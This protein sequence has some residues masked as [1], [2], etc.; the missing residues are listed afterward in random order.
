MGH[1]SLVLRLQTSGLRHSIRSPPVSGVQSVVCILPAIFCGLVSPVQC[2]GSAVYGLRQ[3]DAEWRPFARLAPHLDLSAEIGH[4][5][6]GDGQPEAGPPPLGG[7]ERLKDLG[8]VLSGGPVDGVT[9]LDRT[10]LPLCP[11]YDG[12]GT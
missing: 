12:E 3:E 7:I 9:E 8:E 5:T 10:E 2:L 6:L 11:V 4:Q 1:R